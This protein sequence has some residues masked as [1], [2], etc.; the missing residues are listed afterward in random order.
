MASVKAD[1]GRLVLDFMWR[2]V[3]CR[4]Y[5]GLDDTKEGRARAKQVKIQ[6]EGE[7]SAG[8]LNYAARF[9]RDKKARTIFAPPAPPEPP[10]G[11]PAFGTMAR[12]FVKGRR[13]F[14]SN[15][16]YLDQ[17]SL[18]V[19][20]LVPFFGEDRSV[21]DDSF[22]IEDVER[23][24]SHMKTLPG[25]KDKTMSSVRVNKARNLLRKVLDRAVKK[26]LLKANPV[27]EVPRLRENPAEID[28][29]SWQEVRLLFD[30]GLKDDPEMRRFY[31]V[32]IFSGLRT[33]ELISL[34]WDDLDWNSIPPLAVI[35]HSFT[36]LDG[37]HLTKTAG[38]ARAVELRPAAIR[39]LKEQRTASR[40]K[41]EFV[42]GNR[43]GGPLDRDNLANRAWYPA[44]RRAG[45]RARKPYQCRHSFATLALSSGE[46]IGWVASQMGHVNSKMIIEHYYRFIPNLTRQDG[47]AFDKA[48]AGFGL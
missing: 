17:M 13:V 35:K 3:R 11:P 2:G 34:K 7:I 36:K 20:H 25:L 48:A 46:A 40:L 16:H 47:S 31:T 23:F 41:S 24:V 42:F 14:F 37:E 39:A 27:E 44:L 22:T 15:A 5:L 12:D 30:K 19:T 1:K 18:L 38:S 6:V 4:P 43:D 21:T 26:G 10:A 32:A 8:T 29:L 33:S 45:I 9:P 28:P